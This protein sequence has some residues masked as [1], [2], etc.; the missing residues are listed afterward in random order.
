MLT[1]E[2]DYHLPPELIAQTPAPHRDKSRMMVLYRHTGEIIHS[3]FSN[4][5][6]Y[7]NK[8]DVL[9]INQTKV[10]PARVWAKKG[11]KEIEILLLKEIVKGT[12]KILCRPSKKVKV[13]DIII[14]SP[15]LEGKVIRAEESG[16]RV[17]R[18]SNQGVLKELKKI[19]Y[20]PLPPYIKRKEKDQTLKE[21]D[22]K[23]YQTVYAKKGQAIAAPT[24]GLHFTPEIL[25][26]IEQKGVT[27]CPII[28]DIGL[29]TFQPV[30]VNRVENHRMLEESY[31]ISQR[32][33]ATINRAKK[34]S[35][36][37]V[38]VGT[39]SVRALE[40]A[41]QKGR[42]RSGKASSRLFIY[43]RYEFKV[44]DSLLTNFHLPKSTLL[45]LVAGFAGLDFIKQAY[46]EAIRKRYR[47]Y[48]YGDCMFII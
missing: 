12:W 9:V 24:A 38:A 30:R 41:F 31:F 36:P 39:T 48:S 11:E 25:K 32:A 43:P 23:R 13:N 19:G 40:S 35:H 42:V 34:K 26:K 27:L 4:F 37:V 46:Q 22:L 33:S 15:N 29:A 6:S 5:P 45:M 18:F 21:L 28:L 10:I 14:L 47:F 2:F 17:I 8:E 16:R 44:V 3:H 7:L 20:A 1:S